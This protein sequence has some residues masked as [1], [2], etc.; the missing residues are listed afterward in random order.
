MIEAKHVEQFLNLFERHVLATEKA[1]TLKERE[2]KSQESMLEVA[3]LHGK[4]GAKLAGTLTKGLQQE[5]R[6]AENSEDCSFCKK[7]KAGE[8][9]GPQHHSWCTR[10]MPS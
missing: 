1:N 9:N 6:N 2:V 10:H 8:Q 3:K 5:I 7:E 4:A